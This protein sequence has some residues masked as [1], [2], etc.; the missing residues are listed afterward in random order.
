MNKEIK[1]PLP[2]N[3]KWD[4]MI[5]TEKG[6]LCQECGKHVSDFRKYSWEKIIKVHSNS[7][8]PVC[9][10]YSK[11][12]LDSWGSSPNSN[13]YSQFFTIPAMLLALMQLIHTSVKAQVKANQQQLIKPSSSK[14]NSIEKIPQRKII[15][16]TVKALLLND[17]STFPVENA[18]VTILEDSLRLKTQTDSM[19]RFSIDI[20][21]KFN[22]FPKNIT[23]IFSFLE[24]PTKSL[25]I[26]K[27]TLEEISFI[28]WEAREFSVPSPPTYYYA[29]PP[30]VDTISTLK[31]QKKKWW[32][33]RKK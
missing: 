2:C 30:E 6:R 25:I 31:P 27:N 33:W 15:S 10:I 24:M 22:N 9:G 26:D 20:T 29:V 21:K 28:L 4:N 3:Q 8:T 18:S 16:G 23:V 5:P 12:Q 11:K 19:G 1:K 14:K 32:Q 17:S 13:S 7:P